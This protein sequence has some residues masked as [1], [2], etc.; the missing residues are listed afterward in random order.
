MLVHRRIM[1]L[2]A[3][4]L[5]YRESVRRIDFVHFL[6]VLVPG[7][8][9]QDRRRRDGGHPG[10]SFDDG[11]GRHTE[12]RHPVSVDEGQI[13]AHRKLVDGP[14]HGL[15]GGVQDIDLIDH[16]FIH[17][18]DAPGYGLGLNHR[19]QLPALFVGELL[20]IVESGDLKP[21][22]KDHRRSAHRT[23]K[24]S[25]PRFIHTADGLVSLCRVTV[26]DLPE[27]HRRIILLSHP[28][29]PPRVSPG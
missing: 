24:G 21:R 20:G 8:L 25:S 15:E 9:G 18:G 13:R 26:L 16:L 6:H 28:S 10:V 2:G 3:V 4:A 1:A 11:D 22:R 19:E 7:H 23:R 29:A 14:F 27:I 5:V 17:H 12:I